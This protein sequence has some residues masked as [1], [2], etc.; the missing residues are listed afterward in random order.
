MLAEMRAKV[1]EE[2]INY[3]SGI[4]DLHIVK[5]LKDGPINKRRSDLYKCRSV[6]ELFSTSRVEVS[7]INRTALFRND[8]TKNS[9]SFQRIQ[10]LIRTALYN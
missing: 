8:T 6:E 4:L 3:Y 10:S 7:T 2:D 5:D 9:F 1:K